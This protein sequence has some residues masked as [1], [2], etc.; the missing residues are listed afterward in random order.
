MKPA[1]V[2][3]TDDYGE[4]STKDPFNGRVVSRTL[5]VS[6]TPLLGKGGRLKR[7]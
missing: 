6:E 4:N 1:E 7:K 5:P 3:E 2:G